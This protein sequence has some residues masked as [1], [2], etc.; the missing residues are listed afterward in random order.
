[1][2]STLPG[3]TLHPL[4]IWG[5][6]RLGQIRANGKAVEQAQKNGQDVLYRFIGATPSHPMAVPCWKACAGKS[7]ADMGRMNPPFRLNITISS[8]NSRNAGTGKTGQA[9]HHVLGRT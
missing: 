9:T 4:A 1:M 6:L 2:R 3:M 8:R 7:R 5:S